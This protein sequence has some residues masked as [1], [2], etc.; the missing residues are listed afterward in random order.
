MMKLIFFFFRKA[1]F[2][3][4]RSQ[5]QVLPGKVHLILVDQFFG[6]DLNIG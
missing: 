4:C 2:V 5:F 6:Q 3:T 1:T